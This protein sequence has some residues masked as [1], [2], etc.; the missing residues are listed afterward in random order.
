M[1]KTYILGSLSQVSKTCVSFLFL[2]LIA[3]RLSCVRRH[4]QLMFLIKFNNLCHI[5]GMPVRLTHPYIL[6]L[7]FVSSDNNVRVVE[8]CL[9][10][11]VLY[12]WKK[13]C[14]GILECNEIIYMKIDYI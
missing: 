7:L 4:V 13:F 5:E 3:E 11:N 10:M 14:L 12:H 1:T 6:L 2:S 9:L 8:V